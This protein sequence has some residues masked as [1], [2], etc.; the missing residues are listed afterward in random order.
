[1]IT[2]T[3]T[4]ASELPREML[5]TEIR[6][7]GT[8]CSLG[9]VDDESMTSHNFQANTMSRRAPLSSYALDMPWQ[10]LGHHMVLSGPAR[11]KIHHRFPSLWST[12]RLSTL[13]HSQSYRRVR[14][15]RTDGF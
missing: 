1:M 2:E 4:R 15:E 11:H 10:D 9:N 14:N 3:L 6:N 8:V 7:G 5:H 13:Q 12:S